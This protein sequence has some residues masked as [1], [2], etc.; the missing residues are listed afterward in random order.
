MALDMHDR[1]QRQVCGSMNSAGHVLAI[2][3]VATSLRLGVLV[4]L[5][6]RHI[7]KCFCNV[8]V[9]LG[10]GKLNPKR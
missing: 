1:D 2:V 9:A 10:G 4:W 8:A 7:A 6:W 3:F 5:P